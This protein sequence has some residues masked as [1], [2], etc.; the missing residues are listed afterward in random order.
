MNCV[1]NK[2]QSKKT[3]TAII[4]PGCTELYQPNRLTYGRYKSFTLLQSRILISL[5]K[6]L[7]EA[8][9]A[10][11]NGKD[12]QSLH[13]FSSK[14]S[15]LIRVPIRLKDIAH[16][17]QYKEIY[18]AA[19]QLG[20]ASIKLPSS[21]SKEYYCIATLF[22][23]VELPKMISGTSIM[24]VELFK[25]AARKLIEIDRTGNDRPGY[26]TR[27]LYEVAMSAR[28]KY[29]YKLYMIIA[30]WK[31]KGGFR[32]SVEEL[33]S[34]LGI[35]PKEYLLYKEFKR[36]VLIPVQQDLERRSDCWFNCTT[37]GFE[38]RNGKKVSYLNFK[39]I[40]PAAEIVIKEKTD[41]IKYL[42]CTHFSFSDYHLRHLDN[43]FSN[44]V[45]VDDFELVLLKLQDLKQLIHRTNGTS[46]QIQFIPE[47]VIK[48]LKNLFP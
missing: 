20:K 11:M 26:F 21:I 8:V 13:I 3:N 10:S 18:E 2:N 43:F 44:L 28:N 7:Q 4:L 17:R 1:E 38:T 46:Q 48:T 23:R 45:N 36:R 40:I 27:Y 30:S 15:N 47:Y 39:I 24:Y 16:P 41:H 31:Q 37:A 32:I 42:L 35:G 14:E 33:K 9:L 6:E 22:P 12:W 19:L 34:Q 25:D 5:I 29:T